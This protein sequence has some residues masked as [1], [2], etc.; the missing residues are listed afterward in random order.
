M[1]KLDVKKQLKMNSLL[2]TA[3]ELFTTNGVSQ[4]SI[5]EISEHAGVAKGTFYLYF[6]DKLDIRDKLIAYKSSKLFE[7]AIQKLEEKNED[8]PFTESLIFI[9]DYVIDKLTENQSLLILI[10]KNLGWGVFKSTLS[11][12]L[13]PSDINLYEYI[14]RKTQDRISQPEVMLFMIVEL[15]SSTCY[16][17]II[18][19]E[20]LP[21]EQYKPYLYDTIR[22]IVRDFETGE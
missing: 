20:P 18:H 15:V 14:H 17:S 6:K 22:S 16:N 8:L 3:F 5:S 10:S 11:N 13:Y 1:G 7:E 4:T 12:E 21:I 9:T 19:S 2:D